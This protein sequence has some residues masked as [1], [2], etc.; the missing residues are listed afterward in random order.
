MTLSFRSPQRLL[1][2]LLLGLSAVAGVARGNADESN[3]SPHG[4]VAA[5]SPYASQVGAEI[6]ARGGNAIDAATATGFALMVAEPGMSGLGGRTVILIGRPGGKVEA[7][8]GATAWPAAWIALRKSGAAVPKSVGWKQ[9]AVPGTLAAMVESQRRWGKLPLPEVVRPAIALARTGFIVSRL[10]EQLFAEHGWKDDSAEL[11]RVFLHPDGTPYLAGERLK[12][13]DLA[14]TLELIAVKG[15]SVLY[16]GEIGR[17]LLAQ[18]E[19]EGGYVRAPDLEAYRPQTPKLNEITYGD[20]RLVAMD[21]P[22]AG[23]ALLWRMQVLGKLPRY[24]DRTDDTQ[25]LAELLAAP[26]PTGPARESDEDERKRL[27]AGDGVEKAAREIAAHVAM[28][29][30]TLP[31]PDAA[32]V[33]NTTHFTIADGSGTVVSV[34]QTLGPFFGPGVVLPGYGITFASTMGYLRDTDP[35]I[36]P[37]SSIVPTLVFDR[38]G[39]PEMALGG[40]GAA[41]IPGA[42]LQVLHHRLNRGTTLAE[43]LALPRITIDRENSGPLLRM[44]SLER[45]EMQTLAAALKSRGIAVNPV[46][47]GQVLGRVHAV[48]RRPDGAW[49]GAADPRWFGEAVVPVILPGAM[50]SHRPPAPGRVASRTTRPTAPAAR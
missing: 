25:A 24:P 50:S 29:K 40:A 36:S 34:T 3:V 37:T 9:V 31:A 47:T 33:T 17:A 49:E 42:V 2:P 16:T 18:M 41:R 22:T 48:A 6:L 10:Q 35:S 19:Q 32:A 27:L 14:R 7:L 15:G 8:D 4:V 46:Q 5:A 1:V 45:P 39:S 43:A 21:R 12:Q 28:R 26:L 20:R 11:R 23:R 44:E 13:P 30:S 38:G